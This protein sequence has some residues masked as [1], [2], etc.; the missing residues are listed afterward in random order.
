MIVTMYHTILANRLVPV[1]VL[2]R[3]FPLVSFF[4][5]SSFFFFFLKRAVVAVFSLAQ[6]SSLFFCCCHRCLCLRGNLIVEIIL[7][8]QCIRCSKIHFI[9]PA[10]APTSGMQK[11]GIVKMAKNYAVNELFQ[12]LHCSNVTHLYCCISLIS[13]SVP[14]LV[15]S[16]SWKS[17][18][19]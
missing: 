9:S 11:D 13:P 7:Y 18:D 12:K 3:I 17:V 19:D 5:G 1:K 14:T 4:G 6:N 16:C 2:N 8:L 10:K 15:P